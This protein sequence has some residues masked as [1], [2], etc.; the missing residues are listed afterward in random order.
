[1]KLNFIFFKKYKFQLFCILI[2]LSF[3]NNIK[4]SEIKSPKAVIDTFPK[5]RLPKIPKIPNTGP[6]FYPGYG[7][8]S[9][10]SNLFYKIAYAAWAIHTIQEFESA[11]V[12]ISKMNSQEFGKKVTVVKTEPGSQND[13]SSIS[14]KKITQPI[15]KDSA[16][17]A[18]LKWQPVAYFNNQLFPSA[19]ISLANYQGE[20]SNSLF[21]A[22]RRPLGFIIQSEKSNIP[23]RWEIE[24]VDKDYFDKAHGSFVY[25]QGNSVCL[26]NADSIPWNFKKLAQNLSPTP[27]SMYYRLFDEKGNKVEKLVT[28]TIRSINDCVM[29]YNGLDLR[30]LFSAYVQ[31]DD[32]AK[33]DPILRDGLNTKMVTDFLG[34]QRNE[35]YGSSYV[36]LQVAAIWK[37]LHDRGFQYTSITDN[38]APDDGVAISQTVRTFDNSLKTNQANCVDGTVVFA[39]ILRKIGINSDLVVVPGHCFLGYYVDDTTIHYLETTMMSDSKYLSKDSVTRYSK[40]IT[41]YFPKINLATTNLTTKEYLLQF[42]AARYKGDKNWI[43]YHENYPQNDPQLKYYQKIVR[44]NVTNERRSFQPLPFSDL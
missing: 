30:S 42:I 35:T 6:V 23:L 18:N 31:E 38:S 29:F 14:P 24:C 11:I 9:K 13:V 15:I 44:I 5:I 40:L 34:Y 2:L 7:G 1:M 37:V 3:C 26:F 39:S 16:D 36:D 21:D 4:A 12:S 19:V 8:N 22:V 17:F 27:V 25:T 41:Q 43:E 28:V 20:S 33:I 32:V 10:M